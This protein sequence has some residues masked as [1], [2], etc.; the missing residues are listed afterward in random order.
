MGNDRKRKRAERRSRQLSIDVGD[1]TIATKGAWLKQAVESSVHNSAVR[2]H[3]TETGS[4]KNHDDVPMDALAMV[5]KPQLL[6]ELSLADLKRI[7]RALIAY[8][9]QREE[10]EREQKRGCVGDSRRSTLTHEKEHESMNCAYSVP[11]AFV[12]ACEEQP[13]L[14]PSR[15]CR[16]DVPK[17]KQP[18]VPPFALPFAVENEEPLFPHLLGNDPTESGARK[19]E[20]EKAEE[21]KGKAEA[22]AEECEEK[23]TDVKW[24]LLA[25]RHQSSELFAGTNCG[26][27]V[28]LSATNGVQKDDRD[29]VGPPHAT[30]SLRSSSPPRKESR[31]NGWSSVRSAAT[32]AL[33]IAMGA[34][35]H[36][37]PH[38]LFSGMDGDDSVPMSLPS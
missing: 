19:Q 24:S 21:R 34:A 11:C 18:P 27:E 6:A 16:L 30:A 33:V 31:D 3:Q 29:K 20:E 36:F 13:P 15:P 37:A 2:L 4:D 17:E 23:E 8:V 9:A 28:S 26:P 12:S 1:P 5:V 14:P 22:E 7:Q 10:E 35:S 38:V 32:S 25:A